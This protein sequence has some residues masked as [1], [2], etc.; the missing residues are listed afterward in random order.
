MDEKILLDENKYL[1][2]VLKEIGNQKL[3]KQRELNE[4][5]RKRR[6]FSLHFADDYYYMDDEEALGE[7][8]MLAELDVMQNNIQN[9]IVRL[10][11]QEY[12][13]YFGKI[14]FKQKGKRAYVSYYV[15]VNNLIKNGKEIPLVCDWRA[16]VSSLFYDYELGD[17]EYIT[18][19]GLVKGDIN[20]KRQ[21]EIKNKN[22]LKIFDSSLAIGDDILKDVLSKASSKKM[23]TIVSSIQKEQN[24][25]IRSNMFGNMLVQGVAGS[26]KTSIALHRIAYLLYQHK[27][28]LKAE[29]VLILSPNTLFSEYISEVLP[30]LGEENMSQ[31]SFYRLAEKELEFLGRK[32]ETREENLNELVGNSAR[33]NRVAYKHTYEFYLSLKEFCKR[34]FDVAF[35]PKDLKFGKD[36]ITSQELLNLYA[37]TYKSKSPAV[38]VEW[39]VDYIIDKLEINTAVQEIADRLKKII[40]PFFEESN[41]LK[42]YADFLVSVGMDFEFTKNGKICFDDLAPLLYIYN[43]FFGIKK[44][45]EVKYLIID[46]MQDYSFV[47]YDVFNSIFDCNK[48]VLG[49]INQC[50]EK[51][52]SK[53]DLEILKNMLNAEYLE[54]NTAYRST[55]EITDFACKIKGIEC[56]KIDRHGNSPK[57]LK[58]NKNEFNN[59]IKNILENSKKYNSIAIL[60]KTGEEAKELYMSLSGIEDVSLILSSDEEIKRVSIIPSY[61]AKGLEFDVVVVPSYSN[62]QF[63]TFLDNNLLYV[64]CTRALHE[65]YLIDFI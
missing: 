57:L 27:N 64:A 47:H 46:E 54:L 26:G 20:L 8:D 12:S 36:V 38:R 3:E 41:I 58:I 33:L 32:I 6:E 2:K 21:F 50:I 45:K 40:Y 28:S 16:P 15:G 17:A 35:T 18:P 63:K 1:K 59:N 24:K 62:E 43:Y 55:Y 14:N 13:P 30:E 23:K 25:I 48:T 5:N 37:G 53:N 56:K 42:I 65:L 60:T 9:Q 10:N 29:D 19:N 11:R 31:M 61:I 7:G 52:L 49:D 22:L 51:I 4:L 44:K 34:Y 39:I